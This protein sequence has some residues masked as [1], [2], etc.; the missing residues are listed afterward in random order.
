MST[1]IRPV[2]P[3]ELTGYLKVLPYANGLPHWEP[4]PA[5]WHG[6]PEAWP[7]PGA[8]AEPAQLTAWADEITQASWLHPQ[9]A[10]AGRQ[11]VGHDQ[12][13]DHRARRPAGAA[14]RR[15]L[16][17]GDRHPPAAGA[18]APDDAGHARRS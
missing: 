10:V 4:F 5:A 9:A 3:D 7:P 6:G 16:D 11:L 12:L 18:A 8:P 15:D 14:G 2:K 17:R 1:E 13:R